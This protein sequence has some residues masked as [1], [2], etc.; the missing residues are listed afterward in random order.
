MQKWKRKGEKNNARINEKKKKG[1]RSEKLHTVIKKTEVC[2]I[3]NKN[4][5]SLLKLSCSKKNWI[6]EYI[7][8]S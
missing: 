4:K 2:L 3:A 1:E 8:Q 7:L 5:N 6:I